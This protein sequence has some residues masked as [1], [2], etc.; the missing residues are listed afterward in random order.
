MNRIYLLAIPLVLLTGCMNLFKPFDGPSGDA[1]LVSA[2]RAA[3][4]RGDFT[5]ASQDYQKLSSAYADIGNS[6]GAYTVLDQYGSGMGTFATAFGSGS[7]VNPGKAITSIANA[8]GSAGTPSAANRVA[9]FQAFQLSLQITDN[10]SLTGLVKLLTSFAFLS[11]MLAE[12]SASP[13]HFLPS[14][15]VSNPTAC[16]NGGQAGCTT[17]CVPGNSAVTNGS[18]ANPVAMETA[19][20]AQ[21]GGTLTLSL[22]QTAIDEI[23]IAVGQVKPSG[24]FSGAISGFTGNT[25]IGD[26]VINA[27]DTGGAGF[28][29]N[30]YRYTLLTQN[31]GT[32]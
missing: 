5:T 2:A 21:I 3:L 26:S 17:A 9:I 27:G 32:Y 25:G 15:L 14:D 29:F 12:A 16:L 28:G 19:T 13:G 4:D 20:S 30:C 31:F 10:T 22:I 11:E 8:I 7:N 1:Q 24:S 18:T 23:I 6:E